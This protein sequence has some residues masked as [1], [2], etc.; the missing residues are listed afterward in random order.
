MKTK[1]KNQEKKKPAVVAHL[2][3]KAAGERL[4]EKLHSASLRGINTWINAIF[5]LVI[6][7]IVK[8]LSS[9][10]ELIC[11]PPH[12]LNHRWQKA[13]Q[14]AHQSLPGRSNWFWH[15]FV[16][17]PITIIFF[18]PVNTA[19]GLMLGGDVA[20]CAARRPTA[21]RPSAWLARQADRGNKGV[22]NWRQRGK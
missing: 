7:N 21:A 6:C 14:R 18:V 1:G 10:N 3:L 4:E 5:T 2:H 17:L 20:P 11:S 15:R 9:T 19:I 12:S 16:H 13:S 8:T 22:M